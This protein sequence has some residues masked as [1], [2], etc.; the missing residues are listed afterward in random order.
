[1]KTKILLYLKEMAKLVLPQFIILSLKRHKLQKPM[2][3][4]FC[5]I[6]G[7]RGWFLEV[8][9]PPRIDGYCPNCS[10]M[11]RHRLMVLAFENGLGA[12]LQSSSRVLHFAPEKW[13]CELF[14]DA[15]VV[16]GKRF[17]FWIGFR[18]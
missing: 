14:G 15:P 11:E 4:R 9:R 16:P 8:G 13:Y 5:N 2:A 17:R 1:M 6:C 10:S 7:Y 18:S 12:E 3:K